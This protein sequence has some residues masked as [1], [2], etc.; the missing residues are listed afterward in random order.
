MA[1][2]LEQAFET[3]R[4]HVS[5]VVSRL[6][7]KAHPE[8]F[9]LIESK[10]YLSSIAGK[11]VPSY[12]LCGTYV[13][14]FQG[15]LH[16]FTRS[17]KFH[18]YLEIYFRSTLPPL[19]KIRYSTTASPSDPAT[20]SR[21]A[22]AKPHKELHRLGY[23][24]KYS[25]MLV[26]IAYERIK[27]LV[28]GDTDVDAAEGVEEEEEESEPWLRPMLAILRKE[29]QSQV[30]SWLYTYINCKFKRLQGLLLQLCVLTYPSVSNMGIAGNEREYQRKANID[31][32]I[33]YALQSA[34]FEHRYDTSIYSSREKANIA[35]LCRVRELFDIIVYFPESQPGLEDIRVSCESIFSVQIR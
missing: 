15:L 14:H 24:P 22:V 33:E 26:D 6:Q 4:P 12:H 23:L 19:R 27:R 31:A 1:K 30:V 28:R 10:D 8:N 21:P 32:R 16:S 3:Y 18:R 35:M 25:S 11:P 9:S 5:P 29:V 13:A 7:C 2:R 20:D 34:L 17:S